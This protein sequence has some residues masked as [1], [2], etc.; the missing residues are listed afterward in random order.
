MK[1]IHRY[2]FLELIKVFSICVIFL[3]TIFIL[4]QMLYMA[5]MLTNRGIT[6]TEGLQLMVYTCPVFMVLSFPLSVLV[7]P[8]T[9]FN[10]LCADNEY[11]AMK[12]SGWS[13]LYLM[14]PVFLFSILIY[15]ATNFIVFYAVPW[16]AN[17]FKQTI[18][19]IIQ[20]RAHI[21]IKPK[22]FNKDFQN[23][24]LYVNDKNENQTLIDIF[25]ADNSEEGTSKV[26][27]A[28]EGIIISDPKN[29]KIKIQ[30]RDGT[31]HDITENGKSYNILSFDRY[32]RYL[33]IPS[34][35]RLMEK[36]TSR[37]SNISYT[38][39]KKKI[40]RKTAEGTAGLGSRTK[41]SKNFSIP[42]SCLIFG[43]T[44]AALG[45]KSSRSG[46]SGGFIVSIIVVALY[47]ITLIFSQNM[48]THG[49]I[50]PYFS[51]WI[52]NIWVSFLTYYLVRKTVK[53]SP[54]TFFIRVTDTCISGYEFFLK[55]YKR[56]ILGKQIK[57]PASH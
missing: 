21:E 24:V 4:E 20:N 18:F 10:Q 16:G 6:F 2:I 7:A 29:F 15:I 39:L 17:S 12:T 47:Y 56:M 48:G 32:E 25:M 27:I 28:K 37:Q 49:L 46:K 36:L 44:G 23:L 33:K 30:F 41:L 54:M 40:R 22:I 8:V 13:F 11:V 31:I 1:T 19:D 35:E 45:I 57:N 53:E 34:M 5:Q 3:T 50:N 55:F 42:F 43:L 51:V 52:P 38:E 9:V 26:I 14:R